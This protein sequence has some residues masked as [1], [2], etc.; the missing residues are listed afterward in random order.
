MTTIR[1]ATP[2][3]RF[4]LVE[5]ASRFLLESDYG[6]IFA[7]RSTPEKLGALV[8]KVLEIG[9]IFVAER[10]FDIDVATGTP[11]TA[12][13]IATMEAVE[14]VGMLAIVILPHLFTGLPFGDEIAW[15]VE[16]EHRGNGRIAYK[17]LR[18]AEEWATRNGANMVKM[19]APAGST[20][21]AFYE[22][23][24]YRPVETAFIKSV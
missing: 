6:P 5:M 21:G 2:A 20:V 19:S 7:E 4:R 23:M 24:G 13:T 16:P 12:D 17:L 3:D 9:V 1:A 10:Q 11:A 22:R 15:W 18:S 14:L 8:D